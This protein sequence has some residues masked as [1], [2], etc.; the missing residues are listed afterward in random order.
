M[1]G[2][3]DLVTKLSS[4]CVVVLS[5]NRRRRCVIRSE[6][7]ILIIVSDIHSGPNSLSRLAYFFS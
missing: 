3:V 5:Q 4:E 7:L 2:S 6:G 1:E